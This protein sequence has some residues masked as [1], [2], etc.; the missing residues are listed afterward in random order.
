MSTALITIDTE[1]TADNSTTIDRYV[2]AIIVDTTNINHNVTTDSNDN[3]LNS[4]NNG[5]G[6]RLNAIRNWLKQNRWRKTKD[7]SLN[8]TVDENTIENYQQQASKKHENNN[9]ITTVTTATINKRYFKSNTSKLKKQ[10]S[11][12]HLST[13]IKN[14]NLKKNYHGSIPFEM[15][16]S[17]DVVGSLETN[18]NST[19]KSYS[20]SSYIKEA[21]SELN[22]NNNKAPNTSS[23]TCHQ[24]NQINDDNI[25]LMNKKEIE[26]INISSFMDD[27]LVNLS[28]SQKHNN[29]N[30]NNSITNTN[31]INNNNNNSDKNA[32]SENSSVLFN[33][34]NY[35]ITLLYI[36]FFYFYIFN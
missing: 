2:N 24:S 22:N 20:H 4:T 32:H 34:S 8:Q 31:K 16:T 12:Q 36:I 3:T 13:N 27:N 28:T 10:S 14:N 6:G 9:T 5:S 23:T 33:S 21:E 11:D 19:S 25:N 35:N 30:N 29:H 7:K 18:E 17:T 1:P 15:D 26:S